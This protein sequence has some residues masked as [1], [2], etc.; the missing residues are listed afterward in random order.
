MIP[1]PS[2]FGTSRGQRLAALLGLLVVTVGLAVGLVPVH[3]DT[4]AGAGYD[5][6]ASLVQHK[7]RWLADSF[8]VAI[9]ADNGAA[10]DSDPSRAPD[11][12]C[13]RRTSG[14]R[15]TSLALLVLGVIGG[16]AGIWAS[17]GP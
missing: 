5:C 15:A 2:E 6:G 4:S 3:A 1:R 16:I 10:V 8:A 13:P 9:R 12:V 17:G 7:G 11:A 14:L